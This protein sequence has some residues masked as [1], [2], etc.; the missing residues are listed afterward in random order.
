M[1]VQSIDKIILETVPFSSTTIQL[2]RHFY[3]LVDG[4][5]QGTDS[6][7]KGAVKL[8]RMESTPNSPKKIKTH[9]RGKGDGLYQWGRLY[10]GTVSGEESVLGR[11][12]PATPVSANPQKVK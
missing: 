7:K 4:M 2:T 11:V 3:T 6:S 5:W 9:L 8:G 1:T 10:T 12:C